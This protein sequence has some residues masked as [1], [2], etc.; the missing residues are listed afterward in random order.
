M[1]PEHNAVRVVDSITPEK[2]K[3]YVEALKSVSYP[4]V[5][6]IAAITNLSR[7]EVMIIQVYYDELVNKFTEV[8]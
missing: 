6:M 7:S 8:K 2:F 3:E 1:A 5:T 4:E